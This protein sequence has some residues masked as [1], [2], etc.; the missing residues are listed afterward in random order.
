VCEYVREIIA[1]VDRTIQFPGGVYHIAVG[2]SGGHALKEAIYE[3]TKMY[4]ADV[5][6]FES[7]AL[8]ELG[9]E[10]EEY[11]GNQV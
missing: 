1:C 6:T 8:K 10:P 2:A 5:E 3:I 7:L 11:E 9:L 4:E